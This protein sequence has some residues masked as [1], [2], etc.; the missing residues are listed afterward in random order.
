MFDDHVTEVDPVEIGNRAYLARSKRRVNQPELAG[1]VG[2]TQTT[3]S[4]LENGK[5]RN[6]PIELLYRIADVCGV[7]RS[8][9]VLLT[10]GMTTSVNHGVSS[11]AEMQMLFHFRRLNETEQDAA[12][13]VLRGYIDAKQNADRA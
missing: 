4:N 7:S 13:R 1:L 3:I 2:T 10:E 11:P 8:Y 6:P 9:M 12:I 5:L